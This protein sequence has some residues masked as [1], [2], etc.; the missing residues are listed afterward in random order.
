MDMTTSKIQASRKRF[1]CRAAMLSLAAGGA[2]AAALF[3]ANS[4]P[5]GYV[6]PLALSSSNFK[7]GTVVAYTPWF[8][9]GTFRGDLMALSVSSA[10]TVNYLSPI[11]RAGPTLDLQN[12]L[13]G[14]RIITTD[15]LG[16]G[17]PFLFASLTPAQH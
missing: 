3:I 12:F 14:R 4:Q 13:T 11:W 9:S 8:E 15:G 7:T 10:G 17:I 5:W 1:T 6:A 2:L 16:N